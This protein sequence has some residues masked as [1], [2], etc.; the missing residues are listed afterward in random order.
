M[1]KE[2]GKVQADAE[3]YKA[4]ISSPSSSKKES[5]KDIHKR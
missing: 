5:D 3:E 2:D 1:M 4:F